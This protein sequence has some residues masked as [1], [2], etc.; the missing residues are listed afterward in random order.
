MKM[1]Q[2]I[3][4]DRSCSGKDMFVSWLGVDSSGTPKS[5]KDPVPM[6]IMKVS[7]CED[8]SDFQKNVLGK[9]C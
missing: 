3:G 7:R 6:L 5:R 1:S 9:S 8:F 4:Q 2:H